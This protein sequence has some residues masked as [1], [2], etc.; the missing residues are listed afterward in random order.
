MKKMNNL[1]SQVLESGP[2]QGTFLLVLRKMKEE[3]RSR[4]VIQGC[5]KALDIYPDDTRLRH[6]LAEAYLET[7]FISRAEAE[8]ERVA[9]DIQKLAASYKLQAE[10]YI[11]QNRAKEASD[12]LGIYIAHQPTDQEA[13]NLLRDIRGSAQEGTTAF[14]DTAIIEDLSEKAEAEISDIHGSASEEEYIELS[15]VATPTLAEIYYS[16]GQINEAI[17][18]YEKVVSNNPNDQNSRERLSEIRSI[19]ERDG[20]L[21]AV[22]H[23]NELTQKKEKLIEILEGWLPRIQKLY[24]V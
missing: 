11:R 17:V 15:G 5:L 10:I 23:E 7:G 24:H 4:E 20:P 22:N 19:I 18:T 16:Q 12:A 9:S 8:L 6:L 2:S 13:L 21:R 1:L 3:G 14:P